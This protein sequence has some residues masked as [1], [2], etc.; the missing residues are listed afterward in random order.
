MWNTIRRGRMQFNIKKQLPQQ[1]DLKSQDATVSY[2]LHSFY[3]RGIPV[4]SH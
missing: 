1:P 2:I 4:G 3:K